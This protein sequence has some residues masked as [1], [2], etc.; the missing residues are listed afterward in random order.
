MMQVPA[1]LL[2]RLYVKGSLRN[3][4]GGVAFDLSNTLGSG[5]ADQVLPLRLDGEDVDP[6]SCAFVIDGVALRFD[7]I[8]AERPM[9]L[10]MNGA[11]TVRAKGRTLAAGEHAIELAFIVTGMGEMRFDVKDVVGG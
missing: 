7:E 5:Y 1:F 2:R 6:A 11:L 3:E 10:A 8:S 9:T 4:G